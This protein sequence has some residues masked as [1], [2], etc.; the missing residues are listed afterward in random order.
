MSTADRMTRSDNATPTNP[1]DGGAGEMVE[2]EEER[3]V[4]RSRGMEVSTNIKGFRWPT[5]EE[6]TSGLL[7]AGVIDQAEA[8][9]LRA[10]LSPS[11][12]GD[13]NV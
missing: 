13:R 1:Q 3:V 4:Y 12:K 11:P 5:P 6:K 9:R 10:A 7:S 2:R 8:D